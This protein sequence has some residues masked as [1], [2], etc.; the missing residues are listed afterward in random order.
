MIFLRGTTL[1][2]VLLVG[3]LG[4]SAGIGCRSTAPIGAEVDRRVHVMN[5]EDLEELP[6]IIG[7]YEAL[8][9]EKEYPEQARED[10]AVGVIWVQCRVTAR[11]W[12][13]RVQIAEGGHY[14]LESEARRVVQQLRFEPARMNGATV[15]TTAYIPVIF[16]R[17]SPDGEEGE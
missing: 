12:P 5:N 17:P 13:T 7:G 8:E 11:G 15:P 14:L 4:L 16:Q 2:R 10:G 9:A 1:I 3:L 6:Q